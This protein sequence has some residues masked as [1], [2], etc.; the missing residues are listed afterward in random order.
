M[1][2]LESDGKAFDG[3]KTLIHDFNCTHLWTNKGGTKIVTVT[4]K[5]E[6]QN[7]NDYKI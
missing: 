7:F 5:F 2:D 1:L 6:G 4:E 3:K